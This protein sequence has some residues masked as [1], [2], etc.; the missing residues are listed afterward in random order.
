MRGPTS[1]PHSL[2][3]NGLRLLA[4]LC[5]HGAGVGSGLQPVT[6]LNF[7]TVGTDENILLAVLKIIKMEISGICP[8]NFKQILCRIFFRFREEKTK[9]F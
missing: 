9:A 6:Y 5:V 1:F 8:F 3:L 2:Q 7:I 4:F